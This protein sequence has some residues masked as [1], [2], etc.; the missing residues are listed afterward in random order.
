MHCCRFLCRDHQGLCGHTASSVTTC[1][2]VKS[3]QVYAKRNRC[4]GVLQGYVA[5][6]HMPGKLQKQAS[7]GTA[8]AQQPRKPN[9]LR[10]HMPLYPQLADS[11]DCQP[12]SFKHKNAP[13]HAYYVCHTAT[14]ARVMSCPL[15]P[16]TPVPPS[17]QA[18]MT[19]LGGHPAPDSKQHPRTAPHM[20]VHP[21]RSSRQGRST[22]WPTLYATLRTSKA[23]NAARA[24]QAY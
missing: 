7:D 1:L 11:R 12:A 13:S 16:V 6:A 24:L 5:I 21:L 3:N 10:D 22:P 19:K 15:Q 2:C 20:Y 14:L 18:C 8:H 23:N 17:A 4:R 9:S